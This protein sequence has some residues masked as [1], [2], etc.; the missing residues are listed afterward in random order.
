MIVNIILNLLDTARLAEVLFVLLPFA[1]I[2]A[3]VVMGV[4]TPELLLFG[5]PMAASL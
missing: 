3:G 5:V 1:S 2:I 4:A